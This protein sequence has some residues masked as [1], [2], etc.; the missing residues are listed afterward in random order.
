MF[1]AIANPA[2]SEA[3]AA[4][5]AR[6][7]AHPGLA[8]I[9]DS[10]LLAIFAAP[11]TPWLP[12]GAAGAVVGAL[13]PAGCSA[14]AATVAPERAVDGLASGFWGDYVTII[15]GRDGA[16]VIAARSPS[17]GVHGF[18]TRRDGLVFLCSHAELLCDL[19]IA[20]P[21]IDWDFAA[22][23]LAFSHLHGSATG[24]AGI[25]EIMAGER[26]V[27]R[28]SGC[29]RQS[30]WSPW[31]FAAPERRI[32]DF[33]QAAHRVRKAVLLAVD[34]LVAPDMR[35]A[36]ELSGGLDSSIV[37]AALAAR[38]RP[39][40]AINLVTPT[41]EGDERRYAR[42]VSEK[43]GIELFELPVAGEIDLTRVE[44]R[45]EARPGMLAMLRLADRGFAAI[46][47]KQ[48]AAAF[49]NGTGGDCIFC[50]LGTT[51]PAV[52]RLRARGI[53]PGLA[54]AIGDVA[55]VHDSNIWTVAR[56]VMR[57]RRRGPPSPIW[58]RNRHFLNGDRLPAAPAFHPWLDEPPDALPG[59]RAHIHA[60][61]AS[62]AHLDG[63]GRHAVAPSIFPLL[64]QPVV[65]A[66]L[67]VPS[68][69]WVAGGR[70]RAVARTAFQADLP[71]IVAERRTKGAMDAFC[72]RTFA[73][74][75][76][77]LRQ[78]LL[79]GRLAGAGLLDTGA[80][81]AYLAR[82]FANRDQLF[83][84]LLPIVDAELWA[85][86]LLAGRR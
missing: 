70:D 23:H 19:G 11:K 76:G 10:A 36:L 69:L 20:A 80:I 44:P 22:Q 21:A 16:S 49:V 37:A 57:R 68:W 3:A 32:D 38:G 25:D 71:R 42:A 84:H 31:T 62:Y 7:A 59:T 27:E 66:C 29:E 28:G 65:E 24:I 30:L 60:I 47:R 46:G 12:V 50:S 86:A 8:P 67:S 74:N 63:Y 9:H 72:A 1:I 77:R 6:I 39:A 81:E 41:G 73:L 75:R 54:A 43:T 26:I 15:A 79:D 78:F 51:A 2:R 34:G 64:A 18:R 35:V 5:K 33:D 17:G 4:W 56:M 14:K 58:P 61:L 52:D 55:R 53:G 82:P 83:Y 40:F 45:I 85:Q 13:Y 48:D